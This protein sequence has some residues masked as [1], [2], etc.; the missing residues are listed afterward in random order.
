MKK[1]IYLTGLLS[2]LVLAGCSPKKNNSNTN[3]GVTVSANNTACPNGSWYS[4][5]QCYNANGSTQANVVYGSGIYADNYSGTASFRIT[6]IAT[7]KKLLKEGM[8]ICD[9]AS[10][11][12]GVYN[13]DAY[14][15]GYVDVIAQFP[16]DGSTNSALVTI[17]AQPHAS[18]YYQSQ[19]QGSTTQWGL[20]GAAIGYVTGIPL[21]NLS[22]YQ[23]AYRNP[24]QIQM[25]M[26]PTNNSQGFELRGYGDAWTGLNRTIVSIK[27]LNGNSQSN[28][29]QFSLLV[30]GQQAAQ[31]T[32]VRC[33]TNNCGL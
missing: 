17:I 27:V 25:T 7:M 24:L 2:A 29:A 11:A 5:G 10:G 33:K 6:N 19:S 13:C 9:R 20:I 16:A 12:K 18:Y 1:I 31:G 8:G 23:G 15:S 4:N 26:S 22:Y 30:G 28:Q 14:I 21:P 32:M 3:S